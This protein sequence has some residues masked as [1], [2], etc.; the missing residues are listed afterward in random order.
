MAPALGGAAGLAPLP[1][2]PGP[3]RPPAMLRRRAPSGGCRLLRRRAPLPPTAQ[4]RTP[5][6]PP[7]RSAHCAGALRARRC[8]RRGV[9]GAPCVTAS[10]VS[11]GALRGAGSCPQLSLAP[12]GTVGP[13]PVAVPP[14]APLRAPLPPPRGERTCD[15]GSPR[16]PPPASEEPPPRPGLAP[17]P[18]RP[19]RSRPASPRQ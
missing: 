14:R 9:R 1:A 18:A 10:G 11:Q 16:R 13:C 15:S 2:G 4:A 5:P 17:P 19:G 3:G 12:S 8:V 6:R 7:L